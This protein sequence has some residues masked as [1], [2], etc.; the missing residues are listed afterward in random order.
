MSDDT[1]IFIG[2]GNGE[3][4][5][6]V[7]RR[8]NRHGLVA[9]ATGT[10]K[11]VTLQGMAENFSARGVPAMS[12]AP[13]ALD[14]TVSAALNATAAASSTLRTFFGVMIRSSSVPPSASLSSAIS[15]TP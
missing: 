10:G 4:Q 15:A 1:S 9:G 5:N 2:L 3:P 7:L 13:S 14:T 6:L 11:T 8:A 12:S